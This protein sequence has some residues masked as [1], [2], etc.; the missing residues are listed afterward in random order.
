MDPNAVN[1]NLTVDDFDSLVTY[2][3]Q[4]QWST[5]DPSQ[6]TSNQTTSSWKDGTYHLTAV[7][8]A[9]FTFNFEGCH[10]FTVLHHIESYTILF[11]QGQLFL[12]MALQDLHMVPSK[13]PL[14]VR[15]MC[16]VPMRRKTH[17][18]TFCLVLRPWH[19]RIT[20]S[21]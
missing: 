7:I 5:P 3:D 15:P 10:W 16:S 21:R 6:D 20:L 17:L 2:A 4:S 12:F 18:D 19:T 14:T 1:K 8:N 9:F 13:F 11:K